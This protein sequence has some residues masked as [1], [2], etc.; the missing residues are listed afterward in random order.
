MS[1]RVPSCAARSLRDGGSASSMALRRCERAV[2]SL[3][4]RCARASAGVLTLQTFITC[5][6]CVCHRCC[7]RRATAAATAASGLVTIPKSVTSTTAAKGIETIICLRHTLQLLAPIVDTLED[8]M[9]ELRGIHTGGGGGGDGGDGSDGGDGTVL[10]Q[11]IVDNLKDPS[12]AW[13]DEQISGILTD[14]SATAAPATGACT[15][16]AA[17]RC[18]VLWTE[19]LMRT[20]HLP[21]C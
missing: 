6:R 19:C 4:P 9:E 5:A 10:L 17:Q 18:G 21:S 3:A 15:M 20:Q 11:A 13:I 8:G 14:V 1:V 7:R 12:L 16:R 2:V